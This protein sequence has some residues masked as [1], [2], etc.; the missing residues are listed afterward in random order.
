MSFLEINNVSAS[1][2]PVSNRTHVLSDINLSVEENEFIG[3][4]G[5][6]KSTLISLL[7]GLQHPTTGE[8]RMD[9]KVIKKPGPDL[10]L[11]FQNYS[12]LPWL[13]VNENI[14]L[15]VKTAGRLFRKGLKAHG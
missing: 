1:F 2:D 6:G 9:G 4:S 8:V 5:S 15:A 14:R 10:G 12:L 3:F 13:T 11:M 7:S